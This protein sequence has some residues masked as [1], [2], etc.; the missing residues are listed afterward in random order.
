MGALFV[1]GREVARKSI[2]HGTPISPGQLA[3]RLRVNSDQATQALAVLNLAPDSPTAPVP[4]VN[5]HRQQ[6]TR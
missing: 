4:T 3:A 2:E 5:G 1:D 6:A